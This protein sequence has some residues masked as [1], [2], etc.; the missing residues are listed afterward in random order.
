MC[1]SG[2][3]N[4]INGDP[5]QGLCGME[6]WMLTLI[7]IASVLVGLCF[8]LCFMKC[9]CWPCDRKRPQIIMMPNYA[10][11]NGSYAPL[12]QNNP[13]YVSPYHVP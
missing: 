3:C 10:A 7:I 9:C 1:A 13:N 8:L 11:P 6:T 5:T 12:G 2:T 4:W